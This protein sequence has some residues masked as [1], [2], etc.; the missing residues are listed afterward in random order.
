LKTAVLSQPVVS[1]QV[2]HPGGR[3][4]FALLMRTLW[5]VVFGLLFVGL[6]AIAGNEHPLHAAERWW[7][8]QA[9]LANIVTFIFLRRWIR[10][11][12]GTYRS[13]FK[14][15]KGELGIH[16]RQF[17]LFIV[18]GFALG[19]IPLYGASYLILGSFTPPD[20]MFQ[21][22]PLWA[23]I[24]ALIVFPISNGLVETPTYIGYALPRLQRMI[25]ISWVA[26]TL[27]GLALAF[28]HVALPLVADVP[29]M[30]WRFVSFIP[31]AIALGFIY[32]RT[33][34]LL[35][36]AAAH[37]IMDLQLAGTVFLMSM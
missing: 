30:L 32:T 21:A 1:T 6:F 3:I 19:A 25:P 24:I 36:I 16:V 8:F 29:Y 18:I 14:I 5:F 11:E 12:G 10:K 33:K 28:Q 4:V 37:S 7:P 27:A 15:G 35:P 22:L 31:L 20:T 9:I 2:T 26:I 17:L 34:K 23:A 13:L